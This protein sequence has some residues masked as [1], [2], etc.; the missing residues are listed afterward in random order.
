MSLRYGWLTPPSKPIL[1]IS[2]VLAVLAVLVWLGFIT[3]PIVNQ[4]LFATLLIAYLV[5]LAGNLFRGI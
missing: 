4:H 5:L 2:V 3:I 1:I